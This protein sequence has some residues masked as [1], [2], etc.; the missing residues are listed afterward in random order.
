VAAKTL[1]PYQREAI[2]RLDADFAAGLNRLA[3]VLFAGGGK[4][5]TMANYGTGH[6]LR[7]DGRILVGTHREELMTQ[8]E[9]EFRAVAPHLTVGRVRAEENDVNADVVIASIP[10]I[11][12][13]E[14]HLQIKDVS[15]V[16]VDE[17]H[18]AVAPSWMKVLDRAG[19]FAGTRTIG[20]TGT[21]VRRDQLGLGDLFQKVSILRSIEWGVKH[22]YLVPSHVIDYNVPDLT[23]TDAE[24]D[25]DGNYLDAVVAKA[26]LDTDSPAAIARMHRYYMGRRRTI[27]FAPNKA[28]AHHVAA[29]YEAQGIRCAVVL[30]DTPT[31]ERK[32]IYAAHKAGEIQ[33]IVNVGVL[34][35]GYN[36][37]G[38]SGIIDLT[39]TRSEALAIQKWARGNRVDRDNPGKKDCLIIRARGTVIE[40]KTPA[41]LRK[42][43]APHRRVPKNTTPVR[44]PATK[45]PAG[46][47]KRSE[48]YRSKVNGRTAMVWRGDVLIAKQTA[49]VGKDPHH[50]ARLLIDLDIAQ[51]K[52]KKS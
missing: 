31:E 9:D 27:T 32:A 2:A 47:P 13:E 18:R 50:L 17:C 44:P 19:S 33:D 10:T 16:M 23:L 51:L 15:L 22:G 52:E 20:W 12:N 3:A 43:A 4:T 5:F 29:A 46:P 11:V 7:H 21:L 41:D 26:L 37:P 49:K 28:V 6:L 42:S 45:A 8:I 48:T 36:D 39:I 38:V 14:R 34:T 1:F 30:G 25:A 40:L 35:E 24:A